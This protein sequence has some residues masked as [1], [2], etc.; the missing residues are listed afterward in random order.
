MHY[1]E[2]M[3][4]PCP[5]RIGYNLYEFTSSGLT[6][7]VSDYIPFGGQL[8][9]EL[10]THTFN[11]PS[12]RYMGKNF[13]IIKFDFEGKEPKVYDM[14]LV[15]VGRVPNGR[16]IGA[17]KAGIAVTEKGFIETDGQMRTNIPHI[18]AIGDIARN[19]MLARHGAGRTMLPCS[20]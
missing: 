19:P 5:K 14:I 8:F 4:D 10:F 2:I 11:G 16:N 12:D 1:A 20:S 3:K 17:D 6:H 7:Y 13:G 15:S 9:N 18:Y